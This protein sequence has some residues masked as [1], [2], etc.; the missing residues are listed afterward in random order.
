VR[1]ASRLALV[2]AALLPA[3]PAAASDLAALVERVTRATLLVEATGRLETRVGS[4]FLLARR[5][6]AATALHTLE[7][8]RL[9]RVSLP[10]RLAGCEARLVAASSAWDVA[11]LEV[12]WPGDAP[13]PG[14]PLD[15]GG[16]LPAGAEVAVTGFGLAHEEGRGLGPLTFRGIVSGTVPSGDSAL[17]ILDLAASTGLSGGA[18]YR[19]DTGAVAGV[20]TR[21][22]TRREAT[23]PGAAVPIAVIESLLSSLAA[24][25]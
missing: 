22:V 9:I 4:G 24:S 3:V 6:Y 13:Y 25:H 23:G 2:L 8:A 7:G 15:A 20:L 12:P 5:G 1:P 17:Y 18:V 10:G 21:V 14:L 19:T 11:I 16:I